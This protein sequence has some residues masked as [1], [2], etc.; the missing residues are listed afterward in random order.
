MAKTKRKRSRRKKTLEFE[1]SITD[2][3]VTSGFSEKETQ[4]SHP[5][6][7]PIKGT[8]GD[9][10]GKLLERPT[11]ADCDSKCAEKRYDAVICHSS[12]DGKIALDIKMWFEKNMH[13]QTRKTKLTP[14][15]ELIGKISPKYVA[16]LE[17]ASKR[18]KMIIILCT[19][20]FCHDAVLK[21]ATH[22]LWT[23]EAE[24]DFQIFPLFF[25][26]EE[27]ESLPECI[28]VRDTHD[29]RFKPDCPYFREIMTEHLSRS[30][31]K[32]LQ[33]EE[34]CTGE[35]HEGKERQNHHQQAQSDARCLLPAIVHRYEN[36]VLRHYG[37]T[38][39][40]GRVVPDSGTENF[41]S[42]VPMSVP[43]TSD[44]SSQ[45]PSSMSG[46]SELLPC[47]RSVAPDPQANV[48]IM[49]PQTVSANLPGTSSRYITTE[50]SEH[51]CSG[52]SQARDTEASGTLTKE[53]FR[54]Q[55]K[56]PSV[57]NQHSNGTRTSTLYTAENLQRASTSVKD[58]TSLRVQNR[59]VELK[60]N[61]EP[62]TV[63][64][65]GMIQSLP[66]QGLDVDQTYDHNLE[67]EKFSLNGNTDAHTDG[68]QACASVQNLSATQAEHS[69]SILETPSS[70]SSS[71]GIKTYNISE[72]S[73][74]DPL[75]KD[76]NDIFEEGYLTPVACSLGSEPCLHRRETAGDPN[77]CYELSSPAC[78]S[79][80]WGSED[81]KLP[82]R[83][84]FER[85]NSTLFVNLGSLVTR[86]D[87]AKMR[88]TE[89]RI[90]MDIKVERR[91]E[92][93][94]TATVRPPSHDYVNK[95]RG[96]HPHHPG[97][98]DT[99]AKGPSMLQSQSSAA[100]GCY[101]GPKSKKAV[102]SETDNVHE[103]NTAD[104]ATAVSA[105]ET[106]VGEEYDMIDPATGA[107]PYHLGAV[108]IDN[109]GTLNFYGTSKCQILKEE[110]FTSLGSGKHSVASTTYQA[111][112]CT[113]HGTD[114]VFSAREGPCSPHK[115]PVAYSRPQLPPRAARASDNEV[116]CVPSSAPESAASSSRKGRKTKLPFT[117][118]VSG[119]RA[120][121][122]CCRKKKRR[123]EAE[124]PRTS[125]A[126]LYHNSHQ[127]SVFQEASSPDIADPYEYI[128]YEMV[129][130]MDI[131]SSDSSLG[132]IESGK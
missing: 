64:E 89:K 117:A 131:P 9:F 76:L 26:F 120:L 37:D 103:S 42:G 50:A 110:R 13:L 24:R 33:H 105:K 3:G 113:D 65:K 81:Q 22:A 41:D 10:T 115:G 109:A 15:V 122:A 127:I 83:D 40:D 38:D 62:T 43:P 14:K 130:Y 90:S 21:K 63:T 45:P 99:R 8:N 101:P 126:N 57:Q 34:K 59:P 75:Q 46:P 48:N 6:Q 7:S 116:Y 52:G 82:D 121:T 1:S 73:R 108:N 5:R 70:G 53:V 32:R 91:K 78:H 77:S 67:K 29:V 20:N 92:L 124:K 36:H 28:S 66:P 85:N 129:D 31:E 19:K 125:Q 112:P 97:N 119:L 69:C 47:P 55:S 12:K 35:R 30:L 18:T 61:P 39:T 98:T 51:G 80:F 60:E 114:Y 71:T 17:I 128:P 56:S 107:T 111:W 44:W 132:K 88:M 123:K 27:E 2:A 49:A 86:E 118:I 87:T 23:W 54:S 84:S 104:P 4:P 58:H 79:T 102:V 68:G 11:V 95:D 74:K 25:G 96:N 93:L 106:D 72:S 100:T 16:S 94:G